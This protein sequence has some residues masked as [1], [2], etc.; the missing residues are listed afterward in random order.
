MISVY[1]ASGF[2][3]SNFCKLYPS[4]SISIPKEDIT[5]KSD[6]ILYFISTTDNYNVYDDPYIDINTN[7]IK[8]IEVLENYRKSGRKGIF[9]FVS[10][11]FVYGKSID[12]LGRS[13]HESTPCNPT[14]FYSITKY[15]AEKLLISYCQTYE[16]E[17]RIFRLTNIIGTGDQKVSK[18][19]NAL[20]YMINNLKNNLPIELYNNGKNIRDFM[21]IT[22]CCR[23]IKICLDKSST[24]EIINI[25]N[26]EPKTIGELINYA[27]EK[28]NSNSN[29]VFIQTPE[30]HNI[31]Q[32]KDMWLNND[33]LLSYGY[34]PNMNTFQSIDKI[35]KEFRD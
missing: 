3:G 31:V 11:W 22:D 27:K 23:A 6:D 28:L 1:G 12:I 25:S 10:S 34:K 24:K 30:F 18:K 17:Y 32:I 21:D 4:E 9:N 14:G 35:I 8:L 29:I 13:A 7:L 20:Q 16:I 26:S 15:A 19:K 33:K 2:I 5:S